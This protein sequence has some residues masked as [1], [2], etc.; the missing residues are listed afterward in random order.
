MDKRKTSAK[1][2]VT[3]EWTK[4]KTTHRRP[5][6]T[7]GKNIRT[8]N[9]PS[10]L[11]P[12][13]QSTPGTRTKRRQ[14]SGGGVKRISPRQSRPPATYDQSLPSS[15]LIL[16]FYSL[17]FLSSLPFL[18]SSFFSSPHRALNFIGSYD[19]TADQSYR[20]IISNRPITCI[21]L[22][23]AFVHTF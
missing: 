5:S 22:T 9:F 15:L 17:S 8:Q 18:S 16:P 6:T 3:F 1:R 19:A 20:L 10:P 23:F 13:S 21:A 12:S 14:A 11:P 2:K 4:I 7:C